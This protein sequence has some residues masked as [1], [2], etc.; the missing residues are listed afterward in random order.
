MHGTSLEGIL[1]QIQARTCWAE[2]DLKCFCL[3]LVKS[4][5]VKL[6]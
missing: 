5:L 3:D 4:N 1:K 6:E 2:R